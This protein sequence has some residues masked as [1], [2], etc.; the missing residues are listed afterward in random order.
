[1]VLSLP[2]VFLFGDRIASPLQVFIMT[3]TTLSLGAVMALMYSSSTT[4]LFNKSVEEETKE[5]DEDEDEL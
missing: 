1:M 2:A 3:L 4:E 5:D